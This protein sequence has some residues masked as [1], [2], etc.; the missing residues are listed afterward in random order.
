MRPLFV[1]LFWTTCFSSSG[2]RLVARDSSFIP[3]DSIYRKLSS[4]VLLVREH[5][6]DVQSPPD[7]FR[8]V[9]SKYDKDSTIILFYDT[10]NR[11]LLRAI[12]KYD[13][14]GCRYWQT[15]EVFSPKGLLYYRE[16]WKW[17]CTN[18]KED[19]DNLFLDG[20]LY[21]KE[22]FT[23]DDNGRMKSR[24]WWYAP[25]GLREY[26][27]SYS[28]GKQESTVIKKNGDQFWD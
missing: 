6:P 11:F 24:V 21:E 26:R 14:S 7:S 27:F 16:G 23:Y 9:V 15:T 2:Q 22:R 20:I 13:K 1:I 18:A 4:I 28:N 12:D 10:M 3:T 17:A 5:C 8:A 25:V 19:P